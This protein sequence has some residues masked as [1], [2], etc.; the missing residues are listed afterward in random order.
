M[1]NEDRWNVFTR[2]GRVSDYLAY[3]ENTRRSGETETG[4]W[5]KERNQLE[6]TCD[7]YGAVSRSHW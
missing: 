1:E 2:T 5:G 6:G 3:V 4:F 7:G